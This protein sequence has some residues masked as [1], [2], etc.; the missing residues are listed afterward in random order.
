MKKKTLMI[1]SIA[2]VMVL[3][4]GGILAYLTD[5]A[6]V[7]NTFTVGNVD[8][9]VDEAKVNKEGKPLGE[10][11]QVVDKVEDAVRVSDTTNP[12]GTIKP[13]NKYHIV[14]GLTYVKDPTMTV[15]KK[16]EESYV[17][18]MVTISHA[19]EFDAIFAPEKAKLIEIFNGYD[20]K[21]WIY[22]GETRDEAANTITYEFRYFDKVNNKETVKPAEDADLVLDALFD[23]ITVPGFI[24]KE[25]L[26]TVGGFNI[27]VEGHAI[28]AAGF[29]DTN[30]N[31]VAVKAIDNAWKAFDAEYTD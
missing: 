29:E 23:S 1:I 5:T 31:G 17:R 3:A 10:N 19:E 11:D 12:D 15:A 2:A 14:P 27:V 25:Q 7:T 21:T 24:T 13:A 26:A 4:V 6:G 20:G 30:E 22:A 9:T 28:Q 18:M 16:S 8:I